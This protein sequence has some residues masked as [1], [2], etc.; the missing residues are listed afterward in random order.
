LIITS[1]LG[2]IFLKVPPIYL[3]A[4]FSSAELF[5]FLF[6]FI[7]YKELR[8]FSHPGELKKWAKVHLSFGARSFLSNVLLDMNTRADVLILGILNSDRVVG[9]YSL[10]VILIDGLFQ[11]PA[12]FRVNYSPIVVNLIKEQK[13]DSL[14]RLV[15]T[16]KRITYGMMVL[17]GIACAGFFPLFIS[18]YGKNSDFQ[19]SYLPFLILLVSL[20]I[21]SGYLPFSNIVLQAGYPATYTFMIFI[22]VAMNITLNSIFASKYGAMGSA[23]AT[24]MAMIFLIPLVKFFSKKKIDFAL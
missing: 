16:G 14:R 23:M 6:L 19:A 3:P 22:Q 7:R 15:R 8:H 10:A 12:A 18:I 24:G 1:L 21:C 17:I 2:I 4:I 13:W 5:V 20:V 11:I 9:I